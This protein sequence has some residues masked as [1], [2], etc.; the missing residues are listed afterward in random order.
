MISRATQRK[1]YDLKLK[2]LRRPQLEEY[3]RLLANE[4]L[5]PEQLHRLQRERA[6]AIARHAFEQSPFYRDLYRSAGLSADDF[7]DEAVLDA[8]PFAQKAAVRE[9]FASI[10][11]PEA[12]PENTMQVATGGS[13]G[14]PTK[15]LLDKRA[16]QHLLAY[17]SNSWWGV[18]PGDNRAMV[19][20]HDLPTEAWRRRMGNLGTWPMRMIQL[21]ANQM[22]KDE[23][24]TFFER[25]SRIRP[26][27]LGGYVGA[28]LQLARVAQESGRSLAPPLAIVTGAAP[29]SAGEKAYLSEVFG[30][31]T[32]DNYQSVEV[33]LIA[34]ECEQANGQHVFSDAR[35]VEIVDDEGRPVGPGET[36]TLAITDL[37][38]RAFPLVRYLIG[39]RASWKTEPCACGRP[40]PRLSPIAGRTTDLLQLPSGLTISGD[41]MT[42]IFDPFPDAVRQFQLCQHA[43]SSI[44]LRCVR[45]DAPDAE[46]AM[47]RVLDK[48]R[49]RARGEVPVRLDVVDEIPHDRGK[50]RFVVR[51]AADGSVAPPT[52]IPS[53]LVVDQRDS[54]SLTTTP[55][56][57]T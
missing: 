25:W 39:D 27:L 35:W 45:G 55:V 24:A 57:T 17:R 32:Y 50:T 41:G 16:M 46:A 48:L 51:E 31:P 53:N 5:A 18:H 40:F 3:R 6:L 10:R 26:G 22:G 54:T 29:I 9:N 43:D 2:A 23:I 13:T 11:T 21:D 12:T 38:N 36:G 28:V 7:R 4:R 20:R 44:T 42:A 56:R 1:M 47:Q 34:A 33:P 30:A 15:V 19:V 49:E 52:L 14:R 37:R 8:L